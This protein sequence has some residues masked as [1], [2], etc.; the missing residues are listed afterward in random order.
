MKP[1]FAILRTAKLK[2]LG[3]VSAS[4]SHTYRTRETPNVF[5]SPIPWTRNGATAPN[6]FTTAQKPKGS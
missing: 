5:L 4:L 3:N 1:A 6:L 2:S